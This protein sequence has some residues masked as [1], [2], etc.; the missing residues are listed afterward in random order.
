M[1]TNRLF[2]IAV[3]VTALV[4][5][6]TACDDGSDNGGG[7]SVSGGSLTITD[8]PSGYYTAQ[9][10]PSGTDISTMTAILSTAVQKQVA[11]GNNGN[12][13]N[14]ITLTTEANKSWSGSGNFPVLLSTGT[15]QH[16]ATVSFSN[17]IGTAQYSSFTLPAVGSGLTITGLPSGEYI[18]MIFPVGTDISTVAAYAAATSWG[19]EKYVATGSNNGGNVFTL[20]M[21]DG[22]IWTG[23][24]NFPVVLQTQPY[25]T[26]TLAQTTVSFSNGIG[27]AQYSSFIALTN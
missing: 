1:K 8:L 16:Y 12:S 13:G 5:S 9:I 4:F 3:L 2:G 21:P 19:N 26:S 6:F 25:N 17:G 14:V 10:F 27:T 7:D 22:G 20:A 18:C 24:G 23:S 15:Q 11:I